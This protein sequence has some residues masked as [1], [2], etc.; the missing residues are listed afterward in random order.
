MHDD[1]AQIADVLIRYATGIDQ[2]DW[3]LFRTCWTDEITADYDSVGQFGTGD[4]I[5]DAMAAIHANMGPTYHRMS[6]FVI[7]VDGD[8]AGV[9][10]YV[11]AVLL[12]TAGDPGNWVDAIGH[13]QDVFVRTADGW[14]I[15][16]RISRTP[17]VL[18]NGEI[19]AAGAQAGGP[20]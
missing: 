6:N 15:S 3:P 7:D 17:R 1:R 19:P 20:S 12:V 14:R 13:Y 4:E 10:S 2:R 18:T 11:H 8:R 5:T 16:S 9:R